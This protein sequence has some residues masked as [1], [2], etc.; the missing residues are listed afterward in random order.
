MEEQIR[1]YAIQT[2]NLT[3]WFPEPR[4]LDGFALPFSTQEGTLAVDQVSIEV[5]RGEIF[6]LV[7]PNGAGKTTLVKML[8]TPILPT[9][10]AAQ[11][12]GYDLSD[13]GR[14]KV[15]I[16][17]VYRQ[18]AQFL[19]GLSCRENLRFYAGLHNLSSSQTERKIDE[20]SR[21]FDLGHFLD[22][23]F[24]TCSTGMKHRLALAR[25]LLNDPTLLFLDES[26]RNLDA[27]ATARFREAVYALAHREGRTI[28]LVT[29]DLDEATELSD[30]VGVMLKGRLQV[31]D[32]PQNLRQLINPQERCHFHI[33]AFTDQMAAQ[34]LRQEG[35]LGLGEKYSD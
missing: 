26:T 12:N 1:R 11:V 25:G 21:L 10:G 31:A 4:R 3:R 13:E 29:H 7:D 9:S 20:L 19:L 2:G 18:R 28:F 35:V 14:I 22:K 15:S 17:L 16:G 30:R 27:L 23:G 33:R 8:C 5:K 6:D 32:T 34:I 24:A